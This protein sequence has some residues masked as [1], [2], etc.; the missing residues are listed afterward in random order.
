[1]LAKIFLFEWRYFTRQPSFYITLLIFFGMA[2]SIANLEIASWEEIKM[3]SPFS[4]GQM[5]FGFDITALFLI[6]NFVAS[7][8]LRDHQSGMFELI[9]CKP[10]SPF[11]YQLGRF[12]GAFAV[13]LTVY[14]FVPLG[15]YLGS[16]MPWIDAAKLGPQHLSYYVNH[17]IHISLPTLFL[18]SCIFYAV[19]I[20]FRSIMS[21]YLTVIVVIV[22]YEISDF[23]VLSPETRQLAALIDPFAGRTYA[24]ITAYWTNA[25]KNTEVL[26]LTGV[27][28]ENRLIWL[29]V[30]I[31]SLIAFGHLFKPLTLDNT[32]RSLRKPAK[33]KK[34]VKEQAIPEA[35]KNNNISYKGLDKP[36]WKQFFALTKF[37]VK[38]VIFDRAFI[39]ISL[40]SL[41]FLII[42]SVIPK[43]AYG[44]LMWPTTQVMVSLISKTMSLMTLI[45]I[46]FY[47]AEIVWRERQIGIGDIIDSS[48]VKNISFWMAKLVA[49]C[50]VIL[51][52]LG[53]SM[54]TTLAL[55]NSVDYTNFEITQYLISLFYFSALPWMMMAILAFFL[56]VIS[57][58]K[59]TGM[60][61]FV[62]FIVSD[63]VMTKF[64]LG[65]NMLRFSHSPI[66]QYSDMSGYGQSIISH[67]WYM[68]YWG[69]LSLILAVIGYGLWQRGPVENLKT[70]LNKLF[71]QIGA[72]GK[73]AI[74][75][76]LLIFVF[77][78]S[79]I[80]YNTKVFNDY[81]TNND[82]TKIHADYEKRYKIYNDD[83]LPTLT[84]INAAV[85][86]Y[87]MQRKIVI[88]AKMSIVNNSQQIIKKFLVSMPGS[89]ALFTNK[90]GYTPVDF[91]LVIEGGSMGPVDGEL[92]THWFEFNVPLMPGEKRNAQFK[93]TRQQVGFTD[94]PENFKIVENGTFVQN[95]EIFPRFGYQESEE[96]LSSNLRKKYDLGEATR[97]HALED[98]RYY[99][100]SLSESMIGINTGYLEFETVV[101]TDVDQIAVAPGILL[102]E[103][104]EGSRRIFHYKVDGPIANYFAYMSGR[105]ETIK[106]TYKSIDFGV[107]YHPSHSM[108]VEHILKTM[109]DSYDYF[110]ENFGEYQHKQVRVL[111]FPGPRNVGQNFPNMIA[112]SEQAGFIHNMSNKNDNDQI[113]WF[114]AHE[115]AHEWWGGQIDAANVQGGTMLVETL[116][117]Y[118]SYALTKQTYGKK[119]LRNMLKFEMDRYLT[120]RTR[121]AINELPLMRVENQPYIHYNKGA[122]VMMSIADLIGEKRL[123]DVLSEFLLKFK[124]VESNFPTTIDLLSFMTMNVSEEESI[125]INRLFKEIDIYDLKMSN[126]EVKELSDK[127]F[128]IT[129]NVDAKLFSVDDSRLES[130]SDLSQMIDIGLFDSD[131]NDSE[132]ESKPLYLKKHVIRS[133]KNVIKVI[134]SQRPK[135]AGIDPYFNLI[136]RDY[137]DNLREF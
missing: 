119:R 32:K 19:A 26:S 113:Y 114:I 76:S 128:E 33:S 111:E 115:M 108:N 84:A 103:R 120:G 49:L 55:Q 23:L 37:E 91:S 82:Y 81:Y 134:V 77:S 46:T 21:V 90:L 61:I 132:V 67:H 59:Y 78:G 83:A 1:M 96:I 70:R 25:E 5:L 17:F 62:I 87:P 136:D 8:A 44:N 127:Q 129:I 88:A 102:S 51:L 125:I 107:Y 109:K 34:S 58:N 11:S 72:R 28:L 45:V 64:G 86:I 97:A 13:L 54:L 16:I 93:V 135:F 14:S 101:S 7:S 137:S 99:D 126:I 29:A 52:I 10:I 36:D 53:L 38:Q 79:V 24:A 106:E 47:S 3:N 131:L 130:E 124:F 74:T 50:S 22:V 66:M 60:F 12:A 63:L 71:Y 75:A 73:Y 35:L 27:L 9:Y 31:S 18:F 69:A 39:F 41:S 30:G 100:N 133:G 6:V 94:A 65:F 123:N 116:A 15:L 4:I 105:Y 110:S 68:I 121:E 92:N 104:I 118:S 42:V 80:Y 2:F 48:P 57:D 85:D 117:Q 95:S 89:L 20:K 98:T 56:Q 122:L 43:G 40:I 112:Y